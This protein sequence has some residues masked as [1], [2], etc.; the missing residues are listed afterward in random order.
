MAVCNRFKN[1]REDNK[2]QNQKTTGIN[3][4]EQILMIA[5]LGMLP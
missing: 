4:L 1:I 2:I 5:E 3:M